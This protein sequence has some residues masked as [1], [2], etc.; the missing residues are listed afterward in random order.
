MLVKNIKFVNGKVE[1][2]LENK[3]FSISKENYIEN[4]ITIDSEITQDKIEYLLEF[5]QVIECKMAMIKLL[6]RKAL[7]EF[8]VVKKI[9]EFEINTKYISS[10]VSSLK[11]A[12]LINDEFVAT[13]SVEKELLKRKGKKAIRTLL[14]EKRIKEEIINK[15]LSEIDEDVYNE[16]F[17][18]TVSKYLKMYDKKSYKMKEQMLKQKLEE[19]GYE[20]SLISTVSIDKNSEDEVSLAVKS[21][22]KILKS[23]KLTLDNYEN[24]NK[25]KI[26]LATKGFSYDIINLA[27]EEVKNY[28]TY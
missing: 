28:E 24:V 25:I 9:K 21:L 18:K 5:E 4:P 16:N 17:E 1:V 22:M 19:L 8:E 27:I 10:I 2:I 20:S 11:N 12:G 14:I 23:K 3:S 7:S 15:V 13:L 26:K 6:N